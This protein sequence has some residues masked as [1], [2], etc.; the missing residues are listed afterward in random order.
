MLAGLFLCAPLHA[1]KRRVPA[2]AVDIAVHS[3]KRGD[4]LVCRYTLDNRTAPGIL[5]FTLGGNENLAGPY[6]LTAV[7][8]GYNLDSGAGEY[9]TVPKGWESSL[10]QEPAGATYAV[11][12]QTRE[13]EHAIR[14]GQK[15]TFELVYE[16]ATPNCRRGHWTVITRDSQIYAGQLE[17]KKP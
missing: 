5:A 2:P 9:V 7:P 4:A 6:E 1:A 3:T 8:A 16:A 12:W 14:A 10:L 15:V 13:P 11:E 17:A